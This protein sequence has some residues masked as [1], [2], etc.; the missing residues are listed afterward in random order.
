MSTQKAGV[1]LNLTIGQR[2]RHHDYKGQRVTGVVHSLSIE[3]GRL[4]AGISLDEPIVIPARSDDEREIRLYNQH[5][6]AVE[7]APFDERDEL[8]GELASHLF[9]ML[10]HRGPDAKAPDQRLLDA[11][12]AALAKVKAFRDSRGGAAPIAC[13][14]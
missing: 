14:V 4:M 8:I 7:L 12:Y 10:I 9:A 1:A 13:P 6:F 2:V 11:G 3:D 5:V